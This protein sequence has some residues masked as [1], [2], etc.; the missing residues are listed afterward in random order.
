[1]DGNI[2]SRAYTPITKLGTKGYFELVIK[3]YP[4]GLMSNY[5]NSLI[6]GNV[7]E[8]QGNCGGIEYTGNALNV[9]GY[10]TTPAKINMV[11]GGTS[12]VSMV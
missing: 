7:I 8:C 4:L 3:I 5:L 9:H 11:C 12:V 6:E 10:S 1:M 2:V